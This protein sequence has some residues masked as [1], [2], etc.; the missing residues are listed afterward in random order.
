MAGRSRLDT[1]QGTAMPHKA[2]V[3]LRRVIASKATDPDDVQQVIR[4]Y[5]LLRERM[6]YKDGLTPVEIDRIIDIC[7]SR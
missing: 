7:R 3:I 6:E 4:D 5:I 2:R 1:F